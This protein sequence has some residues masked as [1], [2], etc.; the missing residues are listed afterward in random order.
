MGEITDSFKSK[1]NLISLAVLLVLVIALPLIFKLVQKTQIF[2]PKASSQSVEVLPS[3]GVTTKQENGR[4]II[5]TS[6]PD[7]QLQITS[8][9]DG[10]PT[11][12]AGFSIKNLSDIS[13]VKEAYAS[14]N[15]VGTRCGQVRRNDRETGEMRNEVYDGDKLVGFCG[16]WFQ[17]CEEIPLTDGSTV[18]TCFDRWLSRSQDHVLGRVCNVD[19]SQPNK[20]L[21]TVQQGGDMSN[22]VACNQNEVCQQITDGSLFTNPSYRFD[23]KCVSTGSAS[24]GNNV[25][26]SC[27]GDVLVTGFPTGET[28]RTNCKDQGKTC[29]IFTSEDGNQVAQCVANGSANNGVLPTGDRPVVPQG[30]SNGSGGGASTKSGYCAGYAEQCYMSDDEPGKPTGQ[31][32]CTGGKYQGDNSNNAC[33]FA[34]G[35]T[36][37][38]STCQRPGTGGSSASSPAN[39][40]GNAGSAANPAASFGGSKAVNTCV[41]SKTLDQLKVELQAA[42]YNGAWNESAAVTAYNNAACPVRPADCRDNPPVGGGIGDKPDGYKWVANC[43]KACLKNSDCPVSTDPSIAGDPGMYAKTAANPDG[44]IN[45]T[46]W[47]YGFQGGNRCLML[48]RDGTPA[49]AAAASPRP[50]ASTT[51]PA[52]ANPNWV[53]PSCSGGKQ[54]GC[55]ETGQAACTNYGNNAQSFALCQTACE[56][57]AQMDAKCANPAPSTSPSPAPAGSSYEQIS[58]VIKDNCSK[59]VANVKLKLTNSL[60]SPQELISGADGKFTNN[61][62]IGKGTA[63]SVKLVL[64]SYDQSLYSGLAAGNQILSSCGTSCNYQLLSKKSCIRPLSVGQGATAQG[65]TTQYR[66]SDNLA[67]LT[68]EN[69]LWQT[70]TP[71]GM[72]INFAISD[73]TPGT[74]SIFVQFKDDQGN[75]F[76]ANPYPIQITYK[77]ALEQQDSGNAAC[78]VGKVCGQNCGSGGAGVCDDCGGGWCNGGKCSTCQPDVI[79]KPASQPAPAA[80]VC[81]R[82]DYGSLEN[83]TQW[84][85]C[86]AQW[87]DNG[88][89]V[90]EGCP[91]A[92][93]V[94]APS[95]SNTEQP[96]NS[97]TV[98]QACSNCG[99]DPGHCVPDCNG[100]W[101]NGGFCATCQSDR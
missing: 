30:G 54:V 69:A 89:L 76:N 80:F 14:E 19:P 61:S 55:K 27:D 52:A 18:A 10:Q 94:I 72:A 28:G 37:S 71:G 78:V 82:S 75:V 100:G 25:S 2:A 13:L 92:N 56:P 17:K 7:I 11:T 65:V 22:R 16:D 48:M 38:C 59:P 86:A 15:F 41:G 97:C 87:G 1:K 85:A 45:K 4:T 9:L 51:A 83:K 63:Y 50:A 3:V 77:S 99:D 26:Y 101:C 46:N 34:G 20:L 35:Y 6:I 47:C 93:Q 31:H 88:S 79:S 43:T 64:D 5:E 8:P 21:A 36:T 57:K 95:S 67:Q 49:P 40:G 29:G 39:P 91:Q 98:G 96:S 24:S 81:S 12:D 23:A 53:G 74:K 62:F 60:G 42:A 70:Y 84:C 90:R 33:Q 73:K 58:G 44:A 32:Y 68:D 66:V